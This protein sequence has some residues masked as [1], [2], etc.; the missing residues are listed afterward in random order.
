M[1]KQDR[2][3]VRTAAELEQKHGFGKR[4]AEIMG[5]ATD[6]QKAANEAN[7]SFKGL[8]AQTVYN[9]L[10][11]NGKL[12]GLFRNENGDL[13]VNAKYLYALDELFANDIN[14]SGKFTHKVNTF[15]EPG[16]EELE[17]IYKHILGTETIIPSRIPLYDF[18]NDG[19][20][21]TGELAAVRL[22][23]LGRRTI[24]S[25][26]WSG[27]VNSEVTLTIDLKNPNKFFHITGVNMWGRTIDEYIGVYG[28]SLKNPIYAD[29]VV[30]E[31]TYGLWTYRKWFS[32]AC[33][34]WGIIE[35]LKAGTTDDAAY[36]RLYD[37][38]FPITEKVI[39]ITNYGTWGIREIRIMR[40]S[41]P[42][43]FAF[44]LYTDSEAA[45][46]TQA[47]ISINI[48]GYWS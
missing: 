46:T 43:S 41:D 38:P 20:I 30:E 13:Y 5:I 11:N 40:L 34:C 4:F 24:A 1:S 28:T 27:A 21:N 48:K 2:Q 47:A 42:T 35:G 36:N 23:M 15:L 9:L 19:L 3:G 10:T 16:Q 6:A 7:D 17:T 39:Q 32:G 8:D 14:M 45:A 37:L 22:S 26:G 33:E 44:G 25:T 31:G 29:Y 12:Q 18:D